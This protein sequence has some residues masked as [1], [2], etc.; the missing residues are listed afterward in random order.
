MA[1]RSPY[2]PGE[3][4][5]PDGV[6]VLTGPAMPGRDTSADD[7]ERYGGIAPLP[8]ALLVAAA[9]PVLLAAAGGLAA[10]A[11]A[12]TGAEVARRLLTP[13]SAGRGGAAAPFGPGTVTIT[14]TTVEVHWTPDR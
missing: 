6:R 5:T 3:I 2:E 7:G 4:R 11:V 1:H 12:A 14:W 13:W 10:L 8:A 9:A